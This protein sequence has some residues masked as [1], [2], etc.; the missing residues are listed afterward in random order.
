[1]HKV[2]VTQVHRI[3]SRIWTFFYTCEV[4]ITGQ[5][6]ILNCTKKQKQNFLRIE[7][8]FI[9]RFLI[10]F[11]TLEKIIWIFRCV[12]D[13]IA[14]TWLWSQVHQLHWHQ[15]NRWKNRL[16]GFAWPWPLW[17]QG[18]FH[19]KT[20]RCYGIERYTWDSFPRTLFLPAQVLCCIWGFS[21]ISFLHFLSPLPPWF[22]LLFV[23]Y[24]S[25]R[26]K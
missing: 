9:A 25:P 1:M 15:K 13:W 12:F 3:T 11:S 2:I 20:W 16:N 14:S 6:P 5:M 24:T 4:V 21:S 23:D 8:N 17:S 19:Y 26:R 7:M 10:E 22:P 18:Q